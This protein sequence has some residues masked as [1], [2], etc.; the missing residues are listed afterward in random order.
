MSQAADGSLNVVL[1][2]AGSGMFNADGHVR[3]DT[4]S[5]TA[6]SRGPSGALRAVVSDDEATPAPGTGSY[7]PDGAMRCV[8]SGSTLFGT[9][10]LIGP[11]GSIRVTVN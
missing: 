3:L 8:S 7:T 11:D 2:E 1:D 10:G 5:S 4:V 9:S 6:G